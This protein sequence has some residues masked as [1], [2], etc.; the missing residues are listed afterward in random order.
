VR[1]PWVEVHA[2]D[3]N[4]NVLATYG[5]PDSTGLVPPG[6]ARLGMD[7][8]SEDGTILYKHELTQATRIPFQRVV[9]AGSSLEVVVPITSSVPPNAVHLEA[10][11]YY[12]NVRTTYY[13]GASNDP[14]GHAPDVLVAKT[15]VGQ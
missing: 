4:D 3:A 10:V 11:L 5:G 12:R 1:E 6:A 14:N 15:V 2:L 13:R 9:P 7:I 8:A